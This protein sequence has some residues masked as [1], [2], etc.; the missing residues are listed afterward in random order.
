MPKEL[1]TTSFFF[2]YP[3]K[4]GLQAKT[5]AEASERLSREPGI[6]ATTWED[7]ATGPSGVIFSEISERISTAST[8][9]LDLTNLNENV[10]LEFAFAVARDRM[11]AIFVDRTIADAMNRY[12]SFPPVRGVVAHEYASSSDIAGKLLSM[13]PD[14]G[15][16][17]TIF[18]REIAP[19]IQGA[20]P[21]YIFYVPRPYGT[22]YDIAL[23]QTL[24][25]NMPRGHELK[26]ADPFE[27][28]EDLSWYGRQ[29]AQAALVV[30]HLAEPAR[31]DADENNR[32][33]SFAAGLALGF[34]VPL[35]LV[36]PEGART[37]FDL[38]S[39]TSLYTSVKNLRGLVERRLQDALS[40]G[41]KDRAEHVAAAAL[42]EE[43]R[44]LDFGDHVAERESDQL[45]RYFIR[46]SDYEVVARAR[47]ALIVGRKGAG[48][49]AAMTAALRELRRERS[50]MVVEISPP[51]YDFE[52]VIALFERYVGRSERLHLAAALWRYL[53]LAEIVV[54]EYTRV[55]ADESVRPHALRGDDHEFRRAV[56]ASGIHESSFAGRLE[57]AVEGLLEESADP[58]SRAGA[59]DRL[60][61]R[62][63]GGRIRELRDLLRGALDGR[64]VTILIDNLDKAWQPG[65]N[66]ERQ[67]LFL[68]A[69]LALV[70]ELERELQGRG[71]AERRPRVG[72]VIFLRSDIFG[73]VRAHARERDKLPVHYLAWAA[74]EALLR[75][76]ERRYESAV[77]YERS[78]DRVWEEVFPE[79]VRAV[80]TP[81]YLVR[82]V[83]PRPRDLVFLCNA[84]LESAVNRSSARV[85]VQ[86]VFD[87]EQ[88]Y[89]AHA[90][91]TVLVEAGA[92]RGAVEQA[93]YALMGGEGPI[94]A[95]S[96]VCERV[97]P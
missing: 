24:T 8:V 71:R 1:L 46:T 72:A 59:A 58:S 35:V 62:L 66:L 67:A 32:L 18:A 19:R 4:P 33:A 76:I 21:P 89:S 41:R 7:I 23:N 40:G 80:P 75:V 48:K 87:G 85:E 25:A 36:A 15:T 60:T 70:P 28:T 95:R 39:Q 10:L 13:R 3:A 43:V 38:E 57:N 31:I 17:P 91:D 69:L 74:P 22:N 73:R 61:E 54:S 96:Q 68:F 82:R 16:T 44:R 14:L 12:R 78:G 51:I 2:A 94:F 11:V 65:A 86:D 20:P 97:R 34:R 47:T 45:S 5:L 56:E 77:E 37:A 50:R 90:V 42:A 30:C 49:T 88:R 92:E 29:V 9:V 83:L 55:L 93:L 64:D 63:Y 27:G 26:T 84:A 81:Q 79:R 6:S 52:A 53:L